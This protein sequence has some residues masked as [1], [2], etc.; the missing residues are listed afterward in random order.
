MEM[1]KFQY[2]LSTWPPANDGCVSVIR[3]TFQY[4]RMLSNSWLKP[5]GIP[6]IPSAQLILTYVAL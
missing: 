1:N 2:D 6:D 3:K 4:L 5:I